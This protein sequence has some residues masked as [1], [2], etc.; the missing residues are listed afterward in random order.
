MLPND[1]HEMFE[2]F[3]GSGQALEMSFIDLYFSGFGIP[4]ELFKYVI[5]GYDFCLSGAYCG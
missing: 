1:A 4:W 5:C 2:N 3:E